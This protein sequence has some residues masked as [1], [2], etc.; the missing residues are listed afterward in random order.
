MN[1]KETKNDRASLKPHVGKV[2]KEGVISGDYTETR[3]YKRAFLR[4]MTKTGLPNNRKTGRIQGIVVKT[5][6][7]RHKVFVKW[8]KHTNYSGAVGKDAAVV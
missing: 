2:P 6:P 1:E 7:V 5:D 3:R 8:I 4:Q